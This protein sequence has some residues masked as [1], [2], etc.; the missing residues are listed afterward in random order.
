MGFSHPICVL[1]TWAS[2]IYMPMSLMLIMQMPSISFCNIYDNDSIMLIMQMS[3]IRMHE[4]QILFLPY[5]SVQI[6]RKI[7]SVQ[8]LRN[9]PSQL[10]VDQ[11]G[12]N[13]MFIM[14][15]KIQKF[16]VHETNPFLP[17]EL[18]CNN[19]EVPSAH[20]SAGCSFFFVGSMYTWMMHD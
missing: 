9:M 20:H 4:D 6:H 13:L 7:Q 14:T 12:N 15:K 2:V 5:H 19:Y 18:D 16:G 3:S 17:S 10:V 11:R 8:V 1:Y